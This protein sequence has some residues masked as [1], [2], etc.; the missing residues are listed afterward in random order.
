[1][2]YP[3]KKLLETMT[4]CAVKVFN[5]IDSTNDTAKAE[6]KCGAPDRSVY[7]AR[8]QSGAHGRGEHTF[9]SYDGGIYFSLLTRE[10]R[11][12]LPCELITSAAAVGIHR[13]L[14]SFGFETKIKWINDL[15]YKDKKVCGVLAVSSG[16]GIITG[17]GINAKNTVFPADIAEKAGTLGYEGL[18]DIMAAKVIRELCFSLSEKPNRI[19]EYCRKY[20]FTLGKHVTYR[21]NGK[22][23]SGVASSIGEDGSLSVSLDEGGTDVLRS[24]EVTFKNN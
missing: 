22:E 4:G 9:F 7:I 23:Y 14:S 20:S 3:D 15:Y 6:A 19:I 10:S 16:D 5:E 18:L 17:V 2:S 1:M 21:I 8:I 11:N 13:A 12:L 24:G